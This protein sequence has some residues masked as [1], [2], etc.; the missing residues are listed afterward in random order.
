LLLQSTLEKKNLLLNHAPKYILILRAGKRI[1]A[2][3]SLNMLNTCGVTVICILLSVSWWNKFCLAQQC[4][5][6]THNVASNAHL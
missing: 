3:Q 6:G 2:S 5:F 4:A 1:N